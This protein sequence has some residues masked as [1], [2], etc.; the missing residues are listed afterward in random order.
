MVFAQIQN[1]VP[2]TQG[3]LVFLLLTLTLALPK[4]QYCSETH[5][6]FFKELCADPNG[7]ES[8]SKFTQNP[9]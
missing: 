1:W 4:I 7:T 3:P 6:K 8:K 2:R 5:F 9:K